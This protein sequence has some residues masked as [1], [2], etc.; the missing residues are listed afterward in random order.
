VLRIL[1]NIL[2][3]IFGGGFLIASHLIDARLPQKLQTQDPTEQRRLLETLTSNCTFDCGSV[4]PTYTKPFDLFAK[5][6]ETGNWRRG[7]DSSTFAASPLRS[8]SSY[9]SANLRV[10]CQP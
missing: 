1:L 9:W 10:A 6:N 5:G 4:S 8:I 7:W 2:W 3:F